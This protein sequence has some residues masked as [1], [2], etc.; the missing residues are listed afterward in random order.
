MARVRQ[1]LTAR[2]SF[3]ALN[4][5]LEKNH[6]LER[7]DAVPPVDSSTDPRSSAP[8]FHPRAICSLA[9]MSRFTPVRFDAEDH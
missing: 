5:M 9:D 7:T 8:D 2:Q 6:F 4:W 1:I 3:D